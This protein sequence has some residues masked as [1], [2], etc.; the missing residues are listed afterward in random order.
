M[1]RD[2]GTALQPG[3][4]SETGFHHVAQA[5]R[6]LRLKEKK[7]KR[8]RNISPTLHNVMTNFN[9]NRLNAIKD[10]LSCLCNPFIG[11]ERSKITY[12]LKH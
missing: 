8:K 12:R 11:S 1:S 5:G 6:E 7:K 4:Q 3:Q 2:C 9:K 10:C